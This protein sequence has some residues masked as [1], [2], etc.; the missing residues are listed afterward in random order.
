MLKVNEN[1]MV[2]GREIH[3][4]IESKNKRFD[5]WVKRVIEYAD[6]KEG[7]DFCT[8][9]Y[10]STGGRPSTDY[11]FT[12][13]AAK[14]I[15]LLERNEKGKEIR[16]WLIE[17][18]TKVDTHKLLSIEKTVLVVKMLNVF[19]YGQNQMEAEDLHKNQFKLT[20]TV[21]DNIHKA[22]YE[23][24]NHL[25][26]IDNNQLKEAL[27]EAFNK[28]LIHRATAKNIRQRIALLD[29]YDLLRN[30]VADYLISTG[31][32]THDALNFADTVKTIA[33]QTGTEI[34]IKDEDNLF[35]TK[36]NATVQQLLLN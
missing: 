36:E 4:T 1:N 17:L 33:Q 21:Q 24:R 15:C 11:E 29:R 16:R 6:I 34:R 5:I 13:D 10:E 3:S 28:G 30:A 25:L 31:V 22:F 7:K 14:E 26:N 8:K 20:H 32:Q 9:V 23:Y 18:S 2:S 12:L 35:Q 27:L 19:K